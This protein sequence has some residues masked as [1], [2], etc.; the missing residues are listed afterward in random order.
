MLLI[1]VSFE[2]GLL[3]LH[4]LLQYLHQFQP[5]RELNLDFRQWSTLRNDR[6]LQLTFHLHKRNLLLP[7]PVRA[8]PRVISI[9]IRAWKA[10]V[11]F[12]WI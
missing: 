8:S 3:R 5:I 2:S 12:T 10:D 9:P 7:I 4:Q 1:L 11:K 6:F